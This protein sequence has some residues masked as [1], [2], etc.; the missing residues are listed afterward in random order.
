MLFTRLFVHLHSHSSFWWHVDM[1]TLLLVH[2]LH[3]KQNVWQSSR[4]SFSPS[5]SG[6]KNGEN[7]VQRPSVFDATTATLNVFYEKN[8]W[9]DRT[10]DEGMWL[11]R[12]HAPGVLSPLDTF[13]QIFSNCLT[14]GKKHMYY[15]STQI[16]HQAHVYPHLVSVAYFPVFLAIC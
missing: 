12:G 5:S 2:V 7:S 10:I 15:V 14:T 16:C 9:N 11:V 6:H 4:G 1:T 3:A 8:L 13:R